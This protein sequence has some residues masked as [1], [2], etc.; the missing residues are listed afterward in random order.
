MRL[1][2]S[3]PPALRHRNYRLLW[4]GM[5]ISVTGTMMQSAALLWHV[6]DVTGQP[7]RWAQWDWCASS[8]SSA[9]RS[10]AA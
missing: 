2:T 5:I 10:S 8:P 3:I 6:Y 7:S 9:S 1:F 4:L